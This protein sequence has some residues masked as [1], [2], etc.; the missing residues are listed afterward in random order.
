MKKIISLCTALGFALSL[1]MMPASMASA[2]S[3]A[4]WHKSIAK[5]VAKKQVYPRAAMMREI[6]GKAKV[7]ITVS[8]DGRVLEHKVVQK[9]GEPI[10][11]KEIVKLVRRIDPLPAPP[12]D[13]PDDKLTFVLPL[14]WTIQ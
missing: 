5:R 7:S 9:T 10:L 1:G 8:R 2:G 3:L 12:A 14:A 4:N 13:V 11:D 6:E